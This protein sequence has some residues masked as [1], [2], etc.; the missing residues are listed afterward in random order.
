M[1]QERE[2]ET[3]IYKIKDIGR[4]RDTKILGQN[5]IKKNCV[6]L[7]WVRNFIQK[8]RRHPIPLRTSPV[9]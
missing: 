6:N 5:K 9:V 7:A 3:N 4:K 1:R 8:P 2:K